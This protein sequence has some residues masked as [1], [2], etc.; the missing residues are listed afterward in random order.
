MVSF[1]YP[2]IV[3]AVGK[4]RRITVRFRDLPEALTD[5]RDRQEALREA[6]DCLEEAISCR[7]VLKEDVPPPSGLSKGQCL[8]DVPLHLAPKLALYLA[9]RRQRTTNSELARRLGCRETVVRRML[10]PKHHSKPET[11]QAALH[12]L[13]QRIRLAVED[14][15]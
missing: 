7:M 4:D 2:A 14:T 9:M 10:N 6:A 15:A 1:S 5:G 8:V 3:R 13:G 11:L 12:A